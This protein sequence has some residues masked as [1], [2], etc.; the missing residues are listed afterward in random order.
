MMID[1]QYRPEVLH[2]GDERFEDMVSYMDWA[3]DGFDHKF[4]RYGDEV[5]VT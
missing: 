4:T 3:S 5:I 2:A 1:R